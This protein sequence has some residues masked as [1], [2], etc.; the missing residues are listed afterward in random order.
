MSCLIPFLHILEETKL[1][2]DNYF[3]QSTFLIQ[4]VSYK[5]YFR[6]NNCLLLLVYTIHLSLSTNLIDPPPIYMKHPL[7]SAYLN[8]PEKMHRLIWYQN[9][10]NRGGTLAVVLL[11]TIKTL[12]LSFLVILSYPFTHIQR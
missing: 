3:R 8:S 1:H 7:A 2:F 6:C 12:Y 4:P 9:I 10:E 11:Y 5:R